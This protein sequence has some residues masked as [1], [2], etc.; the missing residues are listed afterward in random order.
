MYW[1]QCKDIEENNRIG[2]TRVLFKKIGDTKGTF[3]V[4]MGSIKNRNG[5]DL[6]ETEE[7]KKRWR[8]YTE[9]Y[10]KGLN[11]LS[12]QNGVVTNLEPNILEYEVKWDLGSITVNKASGGDG[13]PD[14]LFQ[15]LGT[16]LVAQMVKHPP[17]M[18]ETRVQSLGWEELL[19]KEMAT[20]SS[21]LAWRIPWTE[22]PGRLHP[23]CR[24][25][26]DTTERLHFLSLYFKY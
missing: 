21:T 3:H 16:S 11:D 15:I 12:N 19:E 14:D 5:K 1:L 18:Q 10:K 20:H 6:T 23:W 7:I 13:I 8:E 17:T 9:L 25:E 26:S 24:K 2:K 22:E 4:K